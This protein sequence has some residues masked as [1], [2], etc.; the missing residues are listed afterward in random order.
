VLSKFLLK[1]AQEKLS[2][3]DLKIR[4]FFRVGWFGVVHIERTM[5]SVG[6]DEAKV[7][8]VSRWR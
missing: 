8:A 1:N 6:E 5:K 7:F 2:R 4:R 3:D